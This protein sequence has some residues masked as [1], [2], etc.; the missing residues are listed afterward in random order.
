[1]GSHKGAISQHNLALSLI[2]AIKVAGFKVPDQ[3]DIS[4]PHRR[5]HGDLTA[6]IALRAAAINDASPHEIAQS[7]IDHFKRPVSIKEVS[8]AG[9]GHLNFKLSDQGWEELLS[10]WLSGRVYFSEEYQGQTVVVEFSSP[11]VGKPFSVGHLRSTVIGD[12]VARLYEH[13]GAKTIRVNHIGDWG[14]QFGKLIYAIRLWGNKTKIAEDPVKEMLALYVKFHAEAEKDEELDNKAREIFSQL[15][16][17]DVQVRQEWRQVVNWSLAEY[18][19][20]YRRLSIEFDHLA[21]RGESF[22]TKDMMEDV[23]HELRS[24]KL[25]KKSE[26]AAVLFFPKDELPSTVLVKKDGAT[27]YLLRDL[28]ALKYRIEQWGAERIIYH[29][30]SEQ[31]LHFR[32]LVKTAELLGWLKGKDGQEITVISALHGM[33]RL[34]T[35]K[36][37]TRKGKGILLLDLL[38]YGV[39]KA[40]DLIKSKDPQVSDRVLGELSEQIATGSIKYNDVSHNRTSSIIFDWEK[41]LNLDGNSAPYL[42]YTN[43]RAHGVF[44]K[45]KKD[46]GN[47]SFNVSTISPLLT[48]P[49]ERELILS[50]VSIHRS[51][52]EATTKATPHLIADSLFNLAQNFN[53][54]Y[55]ETKIITDDERLTEARLALVKACAETLQGGLHLLGVAAPTT[56]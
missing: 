34:P 31:T 54:Y 50:V 8:L 25:V 40:R 23:L 36:M 33:Y 52:L 44:R 10:A 15:E 30:G 16:Q 20:L 18:D 53:S 28:A 45:A 43:A 19:K 2:T 7:I 41:A 38:D 11:N 29:V 56:L 13:S 9:P 32:Q 49:K 26:G 27:V 35:G 17:G 6:D 3:F 37:S 24:A 21:D 47:M 5:E 39:E 42:M 51:F 22:Y 12:A 14:T 4:V 1:M 55:A 48:M 46:F